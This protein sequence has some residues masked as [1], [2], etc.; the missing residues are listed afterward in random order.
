MKPYFR[1]IIFLLSFVTAAIPSLSQTF[2]EW[3]NP[4]VNEI[5]RLPMHTNHFAFETVDAA[6][7]NNRC[8]SSNYLTLNGIWNFNW[9][10]DADMRPLD[11][12]KT[13]FNDK[14]WKEM[15]VPGIWELNGYG[16]PVYVN[17]GY[18]WSNQYRNNPPFVPVKNNHVGSY[19]RIIEIP[20]GWHG[21]QVIAHFGSVTSNIYL[22]VNGKFVGYSEDSKLEAEF[23][24]TPFL[25]SGKNL[26]AFQVFRWCDGTYL[27]DQDFWRLCGVARDC[28]LYARNKSVNLQDIRITPDLDSEYRDATLSVDMTLIGKGSV[29]V[30]LLDAG[31]NEVYSGTSGKFT[32][33]KRITLNIADPLKWSAEIPNLYTLIACVKSEEKVIE[34]IPVKVGFRKIEIKGSQLLVNGEP[35][36]IKGADR[37]EM[38]PDGGYIVSR[39]R[40]IQDLEIMKRYNINAVRT[41]HYP[42]DNM[43]YDL[44]D[45]YGIYLV[46]EAN[47]ESHGMGY[48]EKTLA[49]NPAFAQAHLE[50]NKRNV[51]RSFNHPSVIIWS[52]GNEGGSGPNFISCADW[53]KNEDHSRPVQYERAELES[54]TDIFCP[55]YYDYDECIEYC[56][57]KDPVNSR[58]LIQCEYAHAMG[59]SEGGFREYWDLVRKY[60]KFQGGF[61]W[62]FVDQSL[63]GVGKNGVM[64]Y[65]YGGDYNP[66]DGSDNNFNDNGLIS[67]DRYPNPHI[68]EVG[69]YYQNIWTSPVDLS[70]GII[71]VYNENFFRDLSGYRMEWT[72]LSDGKAVQSGVIEDMDVPAQS[73]TE[74]SLP[75][76]IDNLPAGSEIL[77]NIYFKQKKAECLI[78][79][80]QSVAKAQ[81]CIR[82]ARF[83]ELHLQNVLG[84]NEKA[85]APVLDTNDR[86]RLIVNG[87]DWRIEFKRT[88]GYLC[89]YEV[90]DISMIKDNGLLTPNFWRAGTDNDYG[91][92]LQMKYKVW[93][94]PVIKLVK[95]DASVDNDFAVVKAEYEMPE[96]K[97]ILYLEYIINNEGIIE[98]T[99]KMTTDSGAKDIPN[100]YRFGMQLQMPYAMEHSTYYGRGPIENYSDR[101][102]ST[103]IG[104]YSSS[105]DEQ[106]YPYIR[107]QENGGKSDVRWWRQ[108][109]LGGYGLEFISDAPFFVSALHYSIESLDNG[110]R[111]S[112]MHSPEVKPVDYTNICIDK[113]QAGLACVDSWGSIPLEPYQ[114]K[115]G[116]YEFS[117]ILRP[118]HT[119]IH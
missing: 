67:P 24:L 95:F 33:K 55:M 102:N 54:Y 45:E 69:Y 85:F 65:T 44:C 20:E 53:I 36:L 68:D 88:S 100:M 50:R 10:E 75:Y 9:V 93:K 51:Q 5:N 71:S 15:E 110:D 80:G 34:A 40:M 2:N 86:S 64:I 21:K 109:T 117:F 74:F 119:P 111:K 48:R 1:K 17:A 28:Y 96:V 6:K 94:S 23:D 58:P 101:N 70:R 90:K 66:Y 25:R 46:A 114:V 4:A 118:I 26:I 42:D 43:W 97:A 16:D 59:N 104:I 77:L 14:S 52:L 35:I 32:G 57:S 112:Q 92:R 18:A 38:D 98:V 113:V 19:R 49:A 105:A 108:T 60:P 81:L 79:A 91:A 7:N 27:E 3:Q 30:A 41:C 29:E 72:L 83:S 106:F 78:A 13:D 11:F 73:K 63:R 107:P 47:V 12:F 61:I 8:A 39:E 87:R 84:S 89:H 62:D 22:W 116:N 76:R 31:G 99:Q 103:F 37:H 115:Y 82:K 56:E